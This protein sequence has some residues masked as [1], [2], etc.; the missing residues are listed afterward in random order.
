MKRNLMQGCVYSST[1]NVTLIVNT[2]ECSTIQ[3]KVKIHRTR[4]HILCHKGFNT[5]FKEA[6]HLLRKTG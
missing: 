5:M 2:D 6:K 1:G 4:P 3:H